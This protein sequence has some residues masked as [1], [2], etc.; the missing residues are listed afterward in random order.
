[1]FGGV[2]TH[3]FLEDVR[4]PPENVLVRGEGHSEGP[5]EITRLER[6]GNAM[7]SNALALSAFDRALAYAQEWEQFDQ[8][9]S[10]FQGI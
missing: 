3:F 4:I 5:A 9:I 2:Q 6:C 8:P 7:M 1:M 10:E